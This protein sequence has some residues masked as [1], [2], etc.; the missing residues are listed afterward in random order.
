MPRLR[1]QIVVQQSAAQVENVLLYYWVRTSVMQSD[2]PETFFQT[3]ERHW[4]A[5]VKRANEVIDGLP[6][7]A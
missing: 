5:V 2:A 3:L 4:P 1:F 7:L 6:R